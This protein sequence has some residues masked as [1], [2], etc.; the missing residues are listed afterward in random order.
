MNKM[1]DEQEVKQFSDDI[2]DNFVQC[3]QN[4][5]EQSGDCEVD[6]IS[7]NS[8]RQLRNSTIGKHQQQ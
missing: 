6:N 8:K 5:C 3:S 1:N 2:N 7:C 4:I